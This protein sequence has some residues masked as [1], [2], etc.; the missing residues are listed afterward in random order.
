MPPRSS[1]PPM[2]PGNKLMS[3]EKLR[4]NIGA[5]T[6]TKD[7]EYNFQQNAHLCVQI[8]IAHAGR[9]SRWLRTSLGN[10]GPMT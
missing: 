1:C 4:V 5:S 7:E 2:L 8:Q 10:K 3:E 9:P 6:F